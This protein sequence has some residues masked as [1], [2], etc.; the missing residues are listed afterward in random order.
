M[1]HSTDDK[2]ERLAAAAA[3]GAVVAWGLKALAIGVAGGLDRSPL[4]GPLFLVGFLLLVLAFVAAGVALPDGATWRRVIAGGI[5]VVAGIA[6][7]VLVETGV[8]ALVPASAGWVKEEAG[9]WV[10]SVLTAALLVVRRLRRNR[11]RVS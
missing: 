6:F 3:T 4:E 7:F 8:G 5:A 9:L 2:F 11:V 1:S 10:V